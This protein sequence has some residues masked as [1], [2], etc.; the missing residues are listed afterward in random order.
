MQ[1][2]GGGAGSWLLLAGWL[3]ALVVLHELLGHLSRVKILLRRLY[4]MLRIR[5]LLL[6]HML[7]EHLQSVRSVRVLVLLGL[8]THLLALT[9]VV[10]LS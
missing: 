8:I 4:V 2:E 3:L 9:I 10:H 6:E 1:L 5:I 7:L